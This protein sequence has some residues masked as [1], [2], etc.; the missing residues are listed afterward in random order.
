VDP[1]TL[2]KAFDLPAPPAEVE[3]DDEAIEAEEADLDADVALVF[4]A[5]TPPEDRREAFIRAVK[6]AMKG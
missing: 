2:A 3:D 4:D 6:A 5:S 1:E